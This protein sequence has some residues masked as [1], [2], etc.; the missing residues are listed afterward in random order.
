[1]IP[2]GKDMIVFHGN[3]EYDKEG[4]PI[5]QDKESGTKLAGMIK[6]INQ[7]IQNT[8]EIR[9][10]VAVSL[11]TTKDFQVDQQYFIRKLNTLQKKI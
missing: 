2:Y 11:P 3:L 10:P 1:M 9:G 6:Q 7:D 5:G 4:N 8:F